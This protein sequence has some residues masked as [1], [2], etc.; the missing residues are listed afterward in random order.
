VLI[1]KFTAKVPKN[2]AKSRGAEDRF[3]RSIRWA[4]A[5]YKIVG[6]EGRAF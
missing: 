3:V 1:R 2:K 5:A 4:M 6:G